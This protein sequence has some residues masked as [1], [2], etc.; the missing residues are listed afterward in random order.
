MISEEVVLLGPV[1]VWVHITGDKEMGKEAEGY[2]GVVRNDGSETY[3]AGHTR[4]CVDRLFV[5]TT[6]E[7]VIIEA[8]GSVIDWGQFYS[9][10]EAAG[11]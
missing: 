3:A 2:G 7:E 11:D 10:I 8:A 5:K 1:G 6:R 9:I 4:S